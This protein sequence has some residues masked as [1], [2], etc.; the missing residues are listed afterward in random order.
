MTDASYD[1]GYLKAGVPQLE[2]YLLSPELYWPIGD[3][4]PDGMPPYPQLTLGGLLLSLA[5]LSAR[6]LSPPEDG[7][8]ARWRSELE[9]IR[10]HWLVAWEQKARREFH[11]R[12]LLWRDYVE[13]YR[14]NP[15]EHADRFAYEV[16]RR[17]M[18]ELLSHETRDLPDTE[19]ELLSGLDKALQAKLL[20]G[21][22]V[23]EDDLNKAFPPGKYW[24]L[25]RQP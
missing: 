14:Q 22:F 2:R 23:W 25:Y 9:S 17:V 18:L 11:A 20:P 8:Y 13:D 10:S 12:L 6:E 7:E 21:R 19:L 4:P 15:T 3:R 16:S 5:K 1:L 24:Y